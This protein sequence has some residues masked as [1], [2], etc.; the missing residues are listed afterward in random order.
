MKAIITIFTSILF[1][2]NIS[3]FSN[4]AEIKLTGDNVSYDCEIDVPV[5]GVLFT[6]PLVN[7]GS[8]KNVEVVEDTQRLIRNIEVYRGQ[9]MATLFLSFLDSD[10]ERYFDVGS[11]DYRECMVD[12]IKAQLN[13]G[14]HVVIKVTR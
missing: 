10:C 9:T 8:V 1:I 14:G 5:S 12:S 3:A 13:G 11:S 4:S 7:I 6:C 2:M